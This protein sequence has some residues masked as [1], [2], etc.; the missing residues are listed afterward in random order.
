MFSKNSF[1]RFAMC[2]VKGLTPIG[3][4]PSLALVYDGVF[5]CFRIYVVESFK[6]GRIP[7]PGKSEIF[8]VIEL[9]SRNSVLVVYLV[10]CT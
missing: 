9:I 8:Q 10:E 6:G 1:V 4:Q 5:N 7:D 3:R 2:Y